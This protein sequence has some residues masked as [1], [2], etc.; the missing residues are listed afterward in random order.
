MLDNEQAL[1]E[2][3]SGDY[4]AGN[5]SVLKGLEPVRKRPE[6]YI[7]T[8]DEIGLHHLVWEI[9]DNS[10]DEALAG[11]CGAITMDINA[12]GSLT[13]SDD[14]RGVPVDIHPVEGVSALTVIFTVLHAGGKF[15]SDTYKTSGGLHGVGSSVVNALSEWMLVEVSRG[16][17][18]YSQ[19]FERGIPVT[20]L[21]D[22]GV[23]DKSTG[24]TVSFKPDVDI[25][26]D[27]LNEQ[28]ELRF[29]FDTLA[30]RVKQTAY[31]TKGLRLTV[32]EGERQESFF[33][34]NGIVDW[35]DESIAQDNRI[36]DPLI[37]E[38]EH[39][40][41]Q[42]E[43]AICYD[44]GHSKNIRSFVNNIH[45][46]E[47]G[48]HEAAVLRSL[49]KVVQDYG[50]NHD[51][52]KRPLDPND[53]QEGLNA[54]VSVRLSD[55]KF[56]GQTKA[57]LSSKEAG[58]AVKEY[59][60]ALFA[61]YL[62]ENPNTAKILVKK[63]LT[64]QKAR[65]ESDKSRARVQRASPMNSI[66][67]MPDKLADCQ[68]NK[69]EET[70]LY[71]VEGDSAGGSA[72]QARDRRFQA[73]L[74]L[75]GKPLNARKNKRRDVDNSEQIA[76]MTSAIGCGAFDQMDMD[77]LRYGKII[78]M[79][80]ADVDG[81]HI[82]LLVLTYM[83]AGMRQ[84]LREGRVY[85]AVSPL[86]RAKKGNDIRYIADDAEMDTFKATVPNADK[87]EINRFK[88]LGEMDPEDLWETTMNPE[89]RTLLKVVCR[90]DREEEIDGVIEVLMG[91]DVG[92]RKDYIS[93]HLVFKP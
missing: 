81:Y 88:G 43:L 84:L 49:A 70:E 78:I 7:G 21:I 6:M 77:K 75:K 56:V 80:D 93:K 79:A 47:G 14:G 52:I 62:E 86:Y 11:H 66:G 76:L 22:H 9:V 35:I 41:V 59:A 8:T 39:E 82:R 90:D 10:V 26:Q 19:R 5:I 42:V 65:E 61:T 18:L 67:H 89:S 51:M 36:H 71:L 20:E 72:K 60:E 23:T 15:D 91:K 44:K 54:I 68:S 48:S 38:G 92:P 57:K 29:D 17:H 64:A 87:W 34:E 40:G 13:V 63:A 73:I 32:N 31:L 33:S 1:P 30:K 12:D 28:G 58:R 85:V 27:A 46:H 4:G 74:P 53:T 45:T 16:G 3:K 69:L 2:A 55:P 37:A 83:H 24:T 50:N 25:F